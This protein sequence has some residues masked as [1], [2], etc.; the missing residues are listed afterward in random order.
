[1]PDCYR[2]VGPLLRSLDPERAHSV[3]LAALRAGIVPRPAAFEHPALEV[4]LWGRVFRNP[5]GLAAGFDKNAEV[6]D[7]M[8]ALGFGF[9]EVGTVTLRPQSG[10]PRPRVFRLPGDRAM[11]NR[12]GF[13]SDGLERVA[14]RLSAR[15]IGPRPDARPIGVN[16]A[17]NRDSADPVADCAALVARMA[18]LADYLVVNVSSPNTPGLR[19]LQGDAAL[20]GLL[21]AVVAARDSAPVQP[22]LLVK[23]APDIDATGLQ[24]VADAAL[25]AGLD[26][27]IATNTTVAR[28]SSLTD[29]RRRED[30]GLSGVPLFARSTAVLA[31]LYRLTRGRLPLIGVG[32]IASGADAYAKVRAGASLV[33]L[34]TA[35]VYQGPALVQRIKR[36]LVARLRADGFSRLQDA[37]GAD[38]G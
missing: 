14:E 35:L 10:N 9:V 34:Y 2:L 27:L 25:A 37:V 24:V 19:A 32:G 18:P 29:D 33:Q 26:G 16:V 31:D 23:V 4:A 3:T 38:I 21:A 5:V 6:P 28:P 12:L 30:G 20:P 11:I 36:D 22:P 7:A 13:N 8:L 1:M 17:P 15:T